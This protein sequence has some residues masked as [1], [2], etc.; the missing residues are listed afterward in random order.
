ML[1]DG[2]TEHRHN[3]A[4]GIEKRGL[5]RSRLPNEST[6]F[7]GTAYKKLNVNGERGTEFWSSFGMVPV[8]PT[9][10]R[11][12]VTLFCFLLVLD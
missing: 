5:L 8:N 12:Q 2:A 9:T 7:G 3:T 1:I 6:C 11:V 4:R 10:P